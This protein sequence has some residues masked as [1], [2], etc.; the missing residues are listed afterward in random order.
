M[1]SLLLCVE[2]G[3]GIAILDRN[4]RFESSADV[5]L[6]P[7]PDSANADVVVAWMK[8]NDNPDIQR[9]LEA[10]GQGDARPPVAPQ[11]GGSPRP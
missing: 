8:D 2:T 6:F 4:T 5:R 1:E 7:L 11:P 3:I 9:I 10:I